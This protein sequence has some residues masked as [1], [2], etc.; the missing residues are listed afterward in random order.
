MSALKKNI[1]DKPRNDRPFTDEELMEFKAMLFSVN[2]SF[3]CVNPAPM[4]W[5]KAW[6]WMQLKHTVRP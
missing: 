6:Q 2:T 3:H 1:M 4:S 5:A